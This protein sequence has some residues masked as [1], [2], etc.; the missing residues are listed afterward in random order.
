MSAHA[1]APSLP[2]R[3]HVFTFKA[4]LF[5]R[6]AH[7]LRLSLREFEIK[8]LDSQLHASF[9][10]RTFAVDGAMRGGRLQPEALRDHDKAQILE[11]IRGEILQTA[12]FP[13][14]E[15]SGQLRA[16]GPGRWTI[17]ATL[18]VHGKRLAQTCTVD[19]TEAGAGTSD[20]EADGL[21]RSAFAS[22]DV[23]QGRSEIVPS[24][25]GIAPYA[26]FGGAIRVQDR[27]L[28]TAECALGGSTIESLL[29]N[30]EGVRFRPLAH[31]DTPVQSD[32]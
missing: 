6:L 23:T 16:D 9:D 4:G 10:L 8:L 25:F 14:A 19:R 15:L 7:D 18:Q 2:A 1:P 30:P 27:V 26:A 21:G 32:K 22:G 11:T 28:V 29:G 5:A 20:L 31:P 13:L 3:L 24:R 17:D 12:D